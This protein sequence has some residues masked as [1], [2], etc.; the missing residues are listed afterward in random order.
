MNDTQISSIGTDPRNGDVLF[1]DLDSG[2]VKRLA[3][4][5]T[6]GT[7]PPALLSQTG[8]FSNLANLTPNA[9]IVSYEPNVP[10]WSDYAIKSRWFAIKNLTDT[11]AFSENGN[12]TLPD[13]NGLDQTFRHRCD[14]RQS[15]D[16]AQVGN[17]LPREDR[18]EC[19]RH[20][21]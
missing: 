14:A 17:A 5:G 4:S 15:G 16:A 6:S 19:L 13:G 12:W 9:G 3:R 20:R 7:P 1:C 8:A 21:L 10:F 2:Q 11:V 18:D